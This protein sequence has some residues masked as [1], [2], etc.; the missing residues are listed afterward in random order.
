MEL[1]AEDAAIRA[2]HRGEGAVAA[3]SQRAEA[4]RQGFQAVAVRHPHRVAAFGDER[5][6]AQGLHLGGTVLALAGASHAPAQ[7]MGEKL[8]AV[9]DAQHGQTGPEHVGR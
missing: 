3:G 8:H 2:A 9:A 1:Q 4:W 7:R 6:G 5:V